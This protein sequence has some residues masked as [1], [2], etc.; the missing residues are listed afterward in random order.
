VKRGWE[1]LVIKAFGGRDFRLTVLGT[2]PV[3]DHYHRLHLDDGG[4]LGSCGVHP[5]MWVRLWFD[6]H[7]KPHQRA[8][9]LVD[10]DL[11]AGRF[12]LEF[13]VHDGPAPRWAT[14]AKV[15]DTI[16]ATVQGSGFTL[17]DPPPRHLYAI[18]DAASVPAINSLFDA[19]D[20]VPATVWL[21]YAHDAEK[22]LPLRNRAHHTVSWVARENSGRHLVETV[23]AE[24]PSDQDAW[25]WVAAEAGSTRA[26]GRHIRKDLAVDKRRM[27]ALGY[28]QAT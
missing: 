3:N 25:Y 27:S 16:E 23:C 28:W 18:G 11:Q 22:A 9:T 15:G 26:I 21:E 2:E 4:L 19:A 14:S 1:G 5:T 13:A 24:L 12:S 10:P 17:P 7:G 6:D 20:Q 8:Y